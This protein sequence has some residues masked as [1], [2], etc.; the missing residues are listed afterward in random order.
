VRT[1]KRPPLIDGLA[2]STLQ[3]PPGPWTT[4]LEAL[5]AHFLAVSRA[6]WLDRFA[7]DR[8][9]GDEGEP[10]A[11]DTPYRV[12]LE[13]HY[14][15]EVPDEPRIPFE[16][17]VL[18]LDQHLLVA[19]KPHF[20]PVTPSGGHVHETLL[21]RLIRRTGNPDLVPLHRIDRETAGLVLFSVNPAT[22]AAYQALFRER[23]IEKHYEAVA[24]ALPALDFPL[25]RRSRI[26]PGEPFF[27]MGEAPGEAN[28]ETRIDVI[29]RGEGGWRYALQPVTGKKHQLRVHM[30]ALGAPIRN[31]PLYPELRH[32]AVGDFDAPLQLTAMRVAFVDPI[33]GARF[34]ADAPARR[35]AGTAPAA[36]ACSAPSN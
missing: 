23:R 28:S 6:T 3:L 22:R 9:L 16:E 27:R 17:R 14:Y 25:V 35:S 18:H 19:D 29:E 36:P 26:V 8:V 33:S 32:R 5:S 11:P 10:L 13:V 7:R 4:V 21:G 20:L 1:D 12:G 31:D 2:A 30:A 15:R 34:I 24:P